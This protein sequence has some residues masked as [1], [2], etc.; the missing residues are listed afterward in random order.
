MAGVNTPT[1]PDAWA[2]DVLGVAPD[3]VI[4]TALLLQATTK[5][6]TVEGD[7]PAVRVPKIN[8]DADV[9]PVKEGD[10]IPEADP[11]LSEIVLLTAKVGELVRVSREQ[12]S[13]P[14]A[15]KVIS[16][17]M[18]RAITYKCDWMV[19]QQPAP[20]S[21]AVWPPAGLLAKATVAGNITDNL[22]TLIDA[23]AAIENTPGGQVSHIIANPLAYAQLRKFK[24]GT[25]SEESLL[26][27]GTEAGP[28]TLLSVPVLTTSAMP[29]DKVLVLD[30]NQVL[31]AYGDLMIARSAEHYFNRDSYALRATWRWGVGF[32]DV[33]AG[34]VLTVVP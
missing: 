3:T 25:A 31:S 27:A 24:K 10:E 32:S 14:D 4:P 1:S 8:L 30:K 11:D 15:S 13:Q 5:A 17:E 20:T 12:L 16:H 18:K 28:K 19:L 2:L 26:G 9:Q 29:V 33:E 21:P 22:D 34:Q 7:A 23:F 6:G